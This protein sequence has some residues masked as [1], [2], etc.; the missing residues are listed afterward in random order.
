MMYRALKNL[1]LRG[2]VNDAGLAK[3]VLDGII[4]QEQAEE[5]AGKPVQEALG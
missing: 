4:T 1:Y 5:I 2:K 3:A